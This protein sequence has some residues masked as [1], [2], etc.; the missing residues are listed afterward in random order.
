MLLP[1]ADQIVDSATIFIKYYSFNTHEPTRSL[2]GTHQSLPSWQSWG[3]A[4][5]G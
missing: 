2:G 4:D 1:E 3:S 5:L